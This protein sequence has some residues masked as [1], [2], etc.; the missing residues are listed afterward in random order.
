MERSS[1]LEEFWRGLGVERLE[2]KLFIWNPKSSKCLILILVLS[3]TRR[4]CH[5][6]TRHVMH[7]YDLIYKHLLCFFILLYGKKGLEYM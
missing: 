4:V 5:L 6:G 1:L 3:V 2:T 7:L